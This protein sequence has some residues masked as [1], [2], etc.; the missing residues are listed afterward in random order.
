MVGKIRVFESIR[1]SFWLFV[2][3]TLF[4]GLMSVPVMG[5]HLEKHKAK[6]AAEA[7]WQQRLKSR[8]R[9]S[10]ELILY[11]Q[12]NGSY[13]FTPV[14]DSGF[15]W[16]GGTSEYPSVLGYSETTAIAGVKMPDLLR[17]WMGSE[18]VHEAVKKR[19][20]VCEP[21]EPLLSSRWAQGAPYNGMC[22]Y[23]RFDDGTLSEERCLVGC[24][25]TATTEVLRY[26]RYPEALLDTLHGWETEHYRIDTVLPGAPLHW[27]D[28]LDSYS[29]TYTDDEAWA[30]QELS[31]YTGM[32]CRMN[33]GPSA[34]GSQIYYL[35]EPLQRVFG[36]RY[37]HFYDR[38]RYS[39]DS[40]RAMLYDE[41]RRGIPL[42]YSGFN[43]AM[44]GHAF[45]IDGMDSEGRYHVRW[46]EGGNYDGYFDID[47]LNA[48][49]RPDE[50]TELGREEGLFCNQAALAFHPSEQEVWPGDTLDYQSH[51]V[52]VDDVV[53]LRQP[54]TNGYV[55]YDVTLTNHSED[56]ITYTMA[57]FTCMPCDTIDWEKIKTVGITAVTL[58]PGKSRTV[59]VRALFSAA[60]DYLLGMTSGMNDVLYREIIHVLSTERQKLVYG[61]AKILD[62]TPQ[63]VTLEM[64]VENQSQSGWAGD[65][66]TYCLFEEGNDLDYRHWQVLNL[67]P[68]TVLR[69]TVS[70]AG[71]VPDRSYTLHVRCP[72][73]IVY[74]YTFRTPGTS[75]VI[76]SA[77]TVSDKLT[78]YS[79]QGIRVG[80][81]TRKECK[82]FMGSLPQG[83]YLVREADGRSYPIYNR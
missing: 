22:P 21:V 47:V 4:W 9:T 69:D 19:T 70:F 55:P 24:V 3:W 6:Q 43:F 63:Q 82:A 30:I 72:W 12:F 54:D 35:V 75:A 33:Y 73:D 65:L 60:G 5:Q 13:L 62:L 81:V 74:S 79:L 1:H 15:I 17:S 56:T 37:T 44:T 32:A 57:L 2:S 77:E 68:Q 67:A 83:I 7:F 51:E 28:I 41:L 29:G 26:Y 58:Y 40:W 49:E 46:G 71:L 64:P 20:V 23:Y 34:S 11:K 59:R 61:P 27:D 50:V 42:V 38:A 25:A 66:L 52:T 53:S 48:Y 14:H 16:V 80:Q 39:P 76:E 36:Y 10:D 8:I 18:A 45:V 31:L 78:V